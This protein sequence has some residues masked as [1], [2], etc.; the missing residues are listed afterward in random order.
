M[1]QADIHFDSPFPSSRSIYSD[2]AFT[3]F[4]YSEYDW[5]SDS[6]HI[7]FNCNAVIEQLGLSPSHFL[8]TSTH[9]NPLASLSPEQIDQYYDSANNRTGIIVDIRPSSPPDTIPIC[10]SHSK[11]KNARFSGRHAR[12]EDGT[13]RRFKCTIPSCND[14]FERKEHLQR[15]VMAHNKERPHKCPRCSR[16]FG[17]S[18]NMK[19]HLKKMHKSLVDD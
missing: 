4:E 8:D 13:K 11:S 7:I 9:N 15:H 18:D 19:T 10:K 12:V 3:P 6:D 16:S 1:S 2:Y 5:T 17:R 14:S